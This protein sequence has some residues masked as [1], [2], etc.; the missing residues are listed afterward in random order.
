V[1]KALSTIDKQIG[2]KDKRL[3]DR[4]LDIGLP[5]LYESMRL[6]QLRWGNQRATTNA[7]GII[8]V[9]NEGLKHKFSLDD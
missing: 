4:M 3:V 9:V 6:E 1:F 2:L 7:R 5:R 8:K